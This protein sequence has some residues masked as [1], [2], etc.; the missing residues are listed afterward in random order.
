MDTLWL[1]P[2]L[3]LS[4]GEHTPIRL[5]EGLLLMFSAKDPL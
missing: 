4:T 5:Q 2:T 3:N 1:N